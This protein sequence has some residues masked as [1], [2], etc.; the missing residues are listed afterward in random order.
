MATLIELGGWRA[1][2]GELTSGRD[3]TATQAGAAMAE[4]L[5]GEATP[6]QIA[7]FIVALRMKGE[8]VDEVTGMVDAMLAAAAPITLPA[9]LDAIDIV[10][11]GGAPQR[12]VHAL[13]VS[14]MACF[15]AAGAGVAVCKH[16]N[17][18]ASSTSG[19]M[20]LL[21]ALG[22]A[23]ELDGDA[24]ARCVRDAGIG[25]CFARSFHPAMRFAG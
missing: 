3:L 6:A 16:G 11:T 25:F 13:N 5:A 1:V 8:A 9:G 14:T 18:K 4:I 24:V 19:S 7:G 23:V 22:V 12:R 20:D 15:V 21:D 17:R 10:G 2:L